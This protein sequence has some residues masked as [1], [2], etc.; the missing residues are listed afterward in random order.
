MH[1]RQEQ[2]SARQRRR[3]GTLRSRFIALVNLEPLLL[4]VV[5]SI[6]DKVF[7]SSHNQ[8]RLNLLVS[9]FEDLDA[10]LLTEHPE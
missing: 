3:R 10:I 9:V 2:S 8:V 4:F 5:N 6:C 1:L 7:R